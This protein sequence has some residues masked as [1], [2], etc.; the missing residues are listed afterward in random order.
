MLNSIC[1]TVMSQSLSI[2][3]HKH[4]LHLTPLSATPKFQ[5]DLLKSL[6]N[7]KKNIKHTGR[8]C[9]RP[10]L[11]GW[12]KSCLMQWRSESVDVN[13]QSLHIGPKLRAAVCRLN[14]G[15]SPE[16]VCIYFTEPYLS[17]PELLPCRGWKRRTTSE[18]KWLKN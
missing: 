7:V 8:D 18:P 10:L 17:Y 13:H 14:S 11:L 6:L 1:Y 12:E 2:T 16:T 5:I 4:K 15:D 3:N 9:P